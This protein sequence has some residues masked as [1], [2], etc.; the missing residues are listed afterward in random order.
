MSASSQAYKECR[1][2]LSSEVLKREKKE[3]ISKSQIDDM[4]VG[5][6]CVCCAQREKILIWE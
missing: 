1:I 6:V 2:P 4:C 5:C 3:C